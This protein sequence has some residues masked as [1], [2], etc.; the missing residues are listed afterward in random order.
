MV[1]STLMWPPCRGGLV[2]EALPSPKPVFDNE[3]LRFGAGIELLTR[4]LYSNLVI[5]FNTIG[6]QLQVALAEL[7]N[8]E[9]RRFQSKT[10]GL[11]LVPSR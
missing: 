2:S 9:P 8:N 1:P 6:V 11:R 10:Q 5:Q 3:S 7:R 4:H